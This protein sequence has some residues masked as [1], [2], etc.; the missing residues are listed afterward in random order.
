VPVNPLTAAPTVAL[1]VT[2]SLYWPEAEAAVVVVVSRKFAVTDWG[3]FIETVV[4]AFDADAAGPVQ[5][6][7]WYPEF[8]VAR[9]EAAEPAS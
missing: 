6:P 1:N 3:A 2:A 9:M 4:E 7:N 5:L 8:G